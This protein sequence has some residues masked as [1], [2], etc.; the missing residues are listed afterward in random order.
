MS[1]WSQLMRG[2]EILEAGWKGP[3]Q[4]PWKDS[5]P[6][7]PLLEDVNAFSLQLCEGR[8]ILPP[9]VEIGR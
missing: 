5:Q 2:R 7:H 8:A 9:K 1:M 6:T 4:L 3:W